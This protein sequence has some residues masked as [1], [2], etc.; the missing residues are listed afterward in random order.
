[1]RKLPVAIGLLFSIAL[2]AQTNEGTDF[3]LAFMQH[4]DRGNN[5][6]VVMITSKYA[7]SGVVEM[8]LQNWSQAFSVAANQVTVVRLPGAAETIG[9]ETRQTNGI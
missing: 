3:Y 1:M 4:V 9:S 8:P 2:Q 7:T 6:M 5:A